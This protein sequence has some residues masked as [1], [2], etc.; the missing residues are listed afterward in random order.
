LLP[1]FLFILGA[2]TL[3]ATLTLWSRRFSRRGRSCREVRTNRPAILAGLAV[4]ASLA[5][6]LVSGGSDTQEKDLKLAGILGGG[7][8]EAGLPVQPEYRLEQAPGKE[9]GPGGQPAFALLHPE[10]PASLVLAEKTASSL[11]G[12]K[13]KA[14]SRPKAA[15][16]K[17]ARTPKPLAK[18]KGGGKEKAAAK[19]RPKT[20]KPTPAG[21]KPAQQVQTA[22]R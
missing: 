15:P 16:V 19:G 10:T 1:T 20:K 11:Q 21:A 4:V 2:Y 8:L 9:I 17:K 3:Y 6:L 12:R 18:E 14:A 7:K 22:S 13:A 5:W